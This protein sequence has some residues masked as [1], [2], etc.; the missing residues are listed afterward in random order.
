MST[1]HLHLL[2][3]HV[4]VIGTLIGL[5]L[6][7]W[8]VLR[9][10]QGLARVTLGLF[11]VLAVVALATVLTGEPA[12]EAVEGLAGVSE[13]VIERHEAAALLAT[14]AL[15]LLGAVSLGVLAWFRG[16]PLR[17]PVM[18][19]VLALALVPAGMM[20]WTANLGGQIRHT[21]IRAGAVAQ[22]AG[23]EAPEAGEHEE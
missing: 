21:E 11:A 2:L 9:K 13:S 8:A 20:A 19:L 23:A 16:R 5:C 1:V 4:P 15:G 12:E 14:I 10:D 18:V 6:L 22:G 7:A 17:R 3:N